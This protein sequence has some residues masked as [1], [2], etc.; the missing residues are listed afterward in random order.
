M[1]PYAVSL[2]FEAM[3]SKL[4]DS[5]VGSLPSFALPLPEVQVREPRVASPRCSEEPIKRCC[6]NISASVVHSAAAEGQQTAGRL[7]AVK[8]LLPESS[9]VDGKGKELTH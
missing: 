1:S 7:V 8:T 9:F 2:T 5:G 3:S 6:H 4:V